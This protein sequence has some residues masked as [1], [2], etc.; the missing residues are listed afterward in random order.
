MTFK[1]IESDPVG[2]IA[3][4][5]IEDLFLIIWKK[6]VTPFRAFYFEPECPPDMCNPTSLAI[7]MVRYN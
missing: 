3:V 6:V 2:F 7:R 1:S 5:F 4:D